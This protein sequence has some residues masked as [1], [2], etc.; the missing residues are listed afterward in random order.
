MTNKRQDD[1]Y[2]YL[3]AFNEYQGIP[4]STNVEAATK[5]KAPF[6]V[7]ILE[8]TGDEVTGWRTFD[9]VTN[10][11]TMKGIL[12]RLQVPHIGKAAKGEKDPYRSLPEKLAESEERRAE[13]RAFEEERQLLLDAEARANAEAQEAAKAADAVHH[14]DETPAEKE[15]AA[16]RKVTSTSSKEG[17]V[18]KATKKAAAKK[19]PA[20][21][22]MKGPMPTKT[23]DRKKMGY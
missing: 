7:V 4:R 15:K 18:K 22:G 5:A 20:K 2:P 1:G 14:A 13:L 21:S 10:P 11:A 9:T 23:Q 12:D 17:T 16:A 8:W 3:E 6:D 19:A